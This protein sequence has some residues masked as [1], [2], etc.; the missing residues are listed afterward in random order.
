M[1]IKIHIPGHKIHAPL[2]RRRRGRQHHHR[3]IHKR[4][5]AL[6]LGSI[7]SERLAVARRLILALQL[8]TL[9]HTAREVPDSCASLYVTMECKSTH[10][11]LS[12]YSI[13]RA[14]DERPSQA[15][16]AAWTASTS[17]QCKCTGKHWLYSES[18]PRSP[19]IIWVSRKSQLPSPSAAML[20]VGSAATGRHHPSSTA[21][22]INRELSP[23][24]F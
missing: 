4:A 15:R 13:L 2:I 24:Q 3:V 5:A 7:S 9:R 16:L 19:C 12:C 17:T 14:R 1:T 20:F 21:I 23:R 18:H 6:A 11:L 8:T 10:L 22:N